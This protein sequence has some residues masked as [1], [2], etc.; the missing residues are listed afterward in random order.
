MQFS[1]L[2]AS[3]Y[4]AVYLAFV[5]YE[6]NIALLFFIFSPA[7][8]LFMVYSILKDKKQPTRTFDEYFYMDE[9]IR[10]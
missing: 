8:L 10:A 4:L 3:V 9:D 2:F 6:I 7:V 1:I 5:Y